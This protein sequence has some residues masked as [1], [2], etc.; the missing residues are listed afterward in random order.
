MKP[1]KLTTAQA[2]K[3][4]RHDYLNDLQLLL[5]YIDLNKLS[6]AKQM[7]SYTTERMRHL[8]KLEKLGLPETELWLSTLEWNFTMFTKELTT[9]IENGQRLANDAQIAIFL[10]EVLTTLKKSLNPSHDYTIS[11]NVC[12]DAEQWSIELQ[13]VDFPYEH[14]NEWP[15]ID[16]CEI[17]EKNE[18]TSW[19]LVLTGQ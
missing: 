15:S 6:D 18:S 17:G 8:A 16:H 4:A 13:I 1:D 12:A 10:Q 11:I 7:I 14:P 3:Y 2:L 9:S 19:T 5:M